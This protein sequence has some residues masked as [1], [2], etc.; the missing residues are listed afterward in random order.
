[1]AQKQLVHDI[2]MER[3]ELSRHFGGGIPAHCLFLIEGN[4]G[5]GK[6]M[7][8]QRLSFG[9]LEH[10]NTVTYISTE[11]DLTGFIQQ[12]DSLN[13]PCT[14]YILD[15]KLVPISLFPK[16]GDVSLRS[17]FLNEILTDE[18]IFS[19]D[20]IIFDTLSHLL[21]SEDADKHMLFE[22]IAFI[23]KINTLNKSIFFCVD[24]TQIHEKFL[25]TLRAVVDCYV[26]VEAK[27]VLGQFLRV[28][29]IIRFKKSQ[30]EVI[31]TF[32]FKVIPGAGFAI[33]LA[34]LS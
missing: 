3:D 15:E 18:R 13:Y 31:P 24:P 7:L 8:A 23:K 5:A 28:V 17:N 16:L 33:E 2:S 1:M 26:K 20:V 21:I 29:N 6:S 9:F 30:D 25:A 12:M 11:L 14:Q 34:S 27:N 10:K 4:D 32:A 22:L 19:N